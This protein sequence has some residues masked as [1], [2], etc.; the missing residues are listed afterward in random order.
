MPIQK[1]AR[2]MAS[3]ASIVQ[4]KCS[5]LALCRHPLLVGQTGQL[6]PP[7]ACHVLVPV[8]CE[9]ASGRPLVVTVRLFAKVS[10]N[11]LVTAFQGCFA[12]IDEL[13]SE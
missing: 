10:T 7:Q 9:E 8:A 5:A 6:G 11:Q 4:C 13:V 1:H 3:L 12:V 2:V